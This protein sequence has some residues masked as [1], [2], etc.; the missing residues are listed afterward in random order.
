MKSKKMNKTRSYNVKTLTAVIRAVRE[1]R[2]KPLGDPQRIIVLLLPAGFGLPVSFCQWLRQ[3]GAVLMPAE[4]LDNDRLRFLKLMAHRTCA[5]PFLVA[6]VEGW[7]GWTKRRT[8]AAAQIRRRTHLAVEL[9]E[10]C[11]GPN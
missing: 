3:N 10:P 1:C 4:V 7:R 6:T 9:K 2:A 11:V 8:L 5:V